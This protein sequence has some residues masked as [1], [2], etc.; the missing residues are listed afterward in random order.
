VV[1]AST[2][3]GPVSFNDEHR[4]RGKAK[5]MD[6]S[7]KTGE[8]IAGIAMF[9]DAANL[10]APSP[11]YAINDGKFHFF[12]PAVICYGPAK[13]KAGESLRLRYRVAVHNGRW[14]AERL[15]RE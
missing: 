12:T 5:A 6:Y 11:W 3:D 14:D 4:F 7:L 10:N 13:L 2:P 15:K 9:D 8:Q 1:V